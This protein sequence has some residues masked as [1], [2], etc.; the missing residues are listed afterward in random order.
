M[1]R[2][3][4]FTSAA[5]GLTFAAALGQ[6]RVTTPQQQFGFD[7]GDDYHLA[8]YVQLIEYWEK[9]ESES[10]RIALERIGTTA[11]GR[12]MLMA[13]ITAPAN[14]AKLGLYK[15]IA[16]R[17]ALAEGVSEEEA[18]DLARQGK[19]VVWIDGGLHATETLGAQQLMELVYQM[20][21]R[22]D[23]ETLRILDD[24][25]LLAACANPD[26]LDLV[27]DW[28]M[29][30]PEPEKRSLQGLPRLYQKY[31][32][33]DNNRDF[34]MVTQ[35]ETEAISRVLFKEWF[36]QIAYNHH[37]SGPAG[38]VLFAPP[39]RDPF[40]YNLDPL[41]PVSLD[42]VGAAMHSRFVAEGK[43]GATMRNG[44]RYSTWWNGGLRTTQYFHN[45]IGL[46]TETIGSP[47]PMEIPFLL[48]RQLPSGD[49]PYPIQPQTWRFRQSVDYSITANRAV[50]DLASRWREKLLYNIYRMGRNSIERGSRDHW[51]I[52][53]ERIEAVRDAS[54]D[55]PEEEESR[56]RRGLP[57]KYYDEVLK[58]P[59]ARDPRGYILGSGQPD[60]ATAGKFVNALI[61]CG[62]RVHRASAAFRVGERLYPAGS[63]VVKT[64]QAFRPH[65]L[66]MFEP[67]RHPNDFQYPGGP[68]RPPYDSAGWTLAYQM[69][70]KFDRILEGFD[71]PFEPIDGLVEPS[72]GAVAGEA[73]SAGY[74][75]S[76]Q[77]NDAFKAVNRLLA[78][79]REVFWLE[80]PLQSGGT[81]WPAGTMFIPG[82]AETRALLDSIA[83]ETGL[84]FYG[85][86][87]RPRGKALRLSPVRIGLWDRYG[88]SMPSGWMRWIFEQFEFPYQIVYPPTLDEGNLRDRFDVL[89]FVDGSVPDP[90]S[91]R[92]RR[93]PP[94]DPESIPEEYR[95]RL[96]EVTT[97]KTIPQLSR[98]LEEG[99][100]IVAI[101]DSSGILA[102]RLDLPVRD[103]LTERLDDGGEARLPREKFYIPGSLLRAHVDNRHP[104]AFGLDEMVDVYFDNSPAFR[105]VSESRVRQ[106]RPVAWFDGQELLRSGWAWGQHY[107]KG[108]AAVLEASVG[109]GKVLLYGP[110][111]TFRGQ[112]HGTF[113]LLFNGIHYAMAESVEIPT[114]NSQL[115]SPSP[116]SQ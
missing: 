74:L 86:A 54:K 36:P 38:T 56:S 1:T 81:T 90:G 26:G 31:A 20:V 95:D 30:E 34:Y 77:V 109:N 65:I 2:K 66:D 97:E 44:A 33:H 32:G 57:K 111:I 98:F 55:E 50:L 6:S 103:G 16:G 51:T 84:E 41:I 68:P 15:E 88:G 80:Q 47:N 22:E 63:Y 39:F 35:P 78:D 108:T 45:I 9:L 106:V 8:N 52:N 40:N 92:R 46:L 94:P 58:D 24:V 70:V 3:H 112:P 64:A 37:Q 60:F 99:G 102:E 110:K 89:V 107:L 93:R 48:E 29:R 18:R 43:P 69:G 91:R 62:I 73:D 17:L 101:G 114:P 116:G 7:L 11:E 12:P 14:H 105:L 25:I 19:A 4:F 75:L 10:E 83:R 96:G 72:P 100:A 61:K 76:H 79:D 59:D 27:A 23:P 49:L 53:P 71:G 21:S 82:G 42:L 28:Y 115:P 13:L 87:E 67:Q 104:L 113:K 5:L 85:V